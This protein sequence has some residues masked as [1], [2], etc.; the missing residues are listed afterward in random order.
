MDLF[1]YDLFLKEY[2][3]GL[4][5]SLFIHTLYYYFFWPFLPFFLPSSSSFFFIFISLDK[6]I[7][8]DF[9]YFQCMCYI[10]VF[11]V[12]LLWFIFYFFLFQYR[13]LLLFTRGNIQFIYLCFIGLLFFNFYSVIY[14]ANV[15][16]LLRI[17][18]LY[19]QQFLNYS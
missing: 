2:I 13:W 1:Y 15:A 6:I 9:H 14:Y 19:Y 7:R 8:L 18:I 16:C 12:I 5:N 3:L 10:L 17:S 4:I 11:L